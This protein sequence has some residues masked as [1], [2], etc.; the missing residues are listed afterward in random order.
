MARVRE[1]IKRVVLRIKFRFGVK[2]RSEYVYDLFKCRRLCL[3]LFLRHAAHTHELLVETGVV[4]YFGSVLGKVRTLW[5]V[6]CRT[7]S[8][9]QPCRCSGP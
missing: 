5:W 3:G 1:R 9:A 6:V 4:V 7:Y 2:E 8:R